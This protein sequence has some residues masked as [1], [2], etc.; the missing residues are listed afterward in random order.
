MT[1]LKKVS[2][3]PEGGVSYVWVSHRGKK[4]QDRSA[5]AVRRSKKKD[6]D[7]MSIPWGDFVEL[8]LRLLRRIVG[9]S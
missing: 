7:P 6:P 5:A 1:D 9:K 2:A 3:S 8:P 4:K